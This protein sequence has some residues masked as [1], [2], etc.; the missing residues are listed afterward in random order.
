M[1]TEQQLDLNSGSAIP[2]YSVDWR[3]LL[4]FVPDVHTLVVHGEQSDYERT[5]QELGIPVVV[6]SAGELHALAESGSLFDTVAAPV[7][8]GRDGNR[9]GRDEWL[10]DCR[11]ARR[12]IRS[13]GR[14]LIGFSNRWD[15]R[16][17]IWT[18]QKSSVWEMCKVLSTLGFHS[19][20]YFGALPELL[21]PEFI[22]PLKSQLLGF[23]LD[24]R[25][26]HKLPKFAFFLT[27]TFVARFL[28]NFLPFYY[29]V[30]SFEEQP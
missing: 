25:Y 9:I 24:Q 26:R 14:L 15:V 22:F 7:G 13:G 21:A 5:F 4:P 2:S 16:S 28:L 30:A 19:I 6:A 17:R 27:Q 1:Q 12:L 29:V 23:V 18:G 11:A 8:F 3:F 20:R 10:G